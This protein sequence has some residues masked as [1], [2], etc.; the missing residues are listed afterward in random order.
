MN[1]GWVKLH[2]GL[3][4]WEWYD[5]INTKVVFLHLLLVAN[6]KDNQ[7][8]GISIKRGQRLTSIDKLSSEIGLSVSKIRTCLKKLIS[9]NEIASRSHSQ[10]T[11]FTVVNY[12]S[13]QGDDK[14][15][16]KP[17]ANESQT[18]D[19]P[20]STNKNY[21][22]EKEDICKLI[23]DKWNELFEGKLSI[24]LK[25]N[26]KRRSA[27][28]G[29]IKEMKSTRFDFTLLQTWTEYFEHAE[30]SNFLMGEN[31]DGWKM[32]FDFVITKSKLLKIVEG[33]YDN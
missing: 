4:D 26:D 24:P 31:K 6:H 5:D 22:N 16:D 3:L 10:H 8:R 28:N 1:H 18:N 9:T 32:S 30:K 12:D 2:R 17:L 11:V 25:L 7:W 14:Q 13:Y 19:K 23:F 15:N 20:L 27:I 29:C 33:E 21:N